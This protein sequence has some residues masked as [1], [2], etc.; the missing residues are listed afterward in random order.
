MSG[1]LSI[2]CTQAIMF[3]T[4]SH[5]WNDL[6]FLSARGLLL[7]Q[8]PTGISSEC[9]HTHVVGLSGGSQSGEVGPLYHSVCAVAVALSSPCSILW[10]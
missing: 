3:S 1:F 10:L 8:V 2:V 9:M 4:Q 5:P 7:I 6:G